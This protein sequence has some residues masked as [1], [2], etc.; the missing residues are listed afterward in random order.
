MFTSHGVVNAERSWV[1][2]VTVEAKPKTPKNVSLIG[3]KA[4][5]TSHGS[6][7]FMLCGENFR[8]AFDKPENRSPNSFDM[9]T[10][11]SD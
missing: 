7:G 10:S 6:P 2:S 11:I 5:E 4:S 1:S 3:D 9:T 8:F